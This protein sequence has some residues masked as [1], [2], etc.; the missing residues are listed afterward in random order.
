MP[1]DEKYTSFVAKSSDDKSG[2]GDG[3][4]SWKLET[5]TKGCGLPYDIFEEF[6]RE[7]VDMMAK[8]V[9]HNLEILVSNLEAQKKESEERISS[10]EEE[11]VRLRHIFDRHE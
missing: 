6:I 4:F 10:L 11:N 2:W 7:F 5:P 1:C 9:N 3:S 8:K